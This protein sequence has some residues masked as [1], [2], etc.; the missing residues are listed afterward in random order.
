MFACLS[1]NQSTVLQYSSYLQ[2]VL[3]CVGWTIKYVN[4][5]METHESCATS[6]SA[7]NVPN[8][9]QHDSYLSY[10]K[11]FHKHSQKS[12]LN[13]QFEKHPS[14]MLGFCFFTICEKFLATSIFII[15]LMINVL[16]LS[17]DT[18]INVL[19]PCS[20]LKSS[21]R[22]AEGRGD[23]SNV[24]TRGM[25]NTNKFQYNGPRPEGGV[26][27]LQPGWTVGLDV[28]AYGVVFH[29]DRMCDVCP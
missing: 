3:A 19:L 5:R 9:T 2:Y 4:R 21:W 6:S 16:I 13:K 10:F 29:K 18:W 22:R 23:S 26:L 7:L 24:K 1:F 27:L 25:T 14:P 28:C 8:L 11:W 15:S 17:L 20:G 12:S